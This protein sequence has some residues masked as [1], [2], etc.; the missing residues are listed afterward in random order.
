MLTATA[1]GY[2]RMHQIDLECAACRA[3]GP[4]YQTS[5]QAYGPQRSLHGKR[6]RRA[7]GAQRAGQL[8]LQSTL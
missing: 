7:H 3:V 8:S 4:A 1:C 2:Q 6:S 5:Q